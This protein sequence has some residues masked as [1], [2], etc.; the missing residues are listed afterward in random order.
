[1]A[2]DS[3]LTVDDYPEPRPLYLKSRNRYIVCVSVPS[4]LKH[5]LA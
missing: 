5:L 3:I 4:R 1:M 2:N